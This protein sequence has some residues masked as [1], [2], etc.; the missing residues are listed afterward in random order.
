ML[1]PEKAELLALDNAHK[2]ELKEFNN[3][4]ENIIMPNFE[5]E[6]ELLQLE[7][8]RKHH[9]ELEEFKESLEKDLSLKY[10]VNSEILE[11]RKKLDTLGQMVRGT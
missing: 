2:T 9:Q 11:L 6:T 1:R 10:H 4:W 7:L 8:R 3:K 5:S